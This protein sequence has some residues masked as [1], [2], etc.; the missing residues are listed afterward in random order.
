MFLIFYNL[1]ENVA[2]KYL[3]TD[4][5]IVNDKKIGKYYK[6]WEKQTAT[7]NPTKYGFYVNRWRS[8]LKDKLKNKKEKKD[9]EDL[10][11]A[12]DKGTHLT[13]KG[14]TI[15]C[16]QG[17]QEYKLTRK[18]WKFVAEKIDQC[19]EEKECIWGPMPDEQVKENKML[20]G[21]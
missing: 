18:Q 20:D 12:L 10:I 9:A 16:D 14:K 6:K 3:S 7:K 4:K 19:M 17:K 5:S 11:D 8:C 21:I 15:S 13:K 1:K 2:R